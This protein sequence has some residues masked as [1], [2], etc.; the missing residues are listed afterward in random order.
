MKRPEE[1]LVRGEDETHTDWRSRERPLDEG[2]EEGR[3]ADEVSIIVSKTMAYLL[4]DILQANNKMRPSP[5]INVHNLLW[6]MQILPPQKC[7]CSNVDK[8]P[9]LHQTLSTS[10]QNITNSHHF[11]KDDVVRESD[12]TNNVPDSIFSKLGLQL[13]RRDRHPIGILKN[14]IYDYFD[15]NY[16]NSF[17]KF[18]DLCP[19][20]PV[21]AV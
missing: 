18:N 7:I 15:T 2:E 8:P 13:H 11:N 14:A 4:V 1:V 17:L 9:H 21:K 5:F 3:R 19:I 12:P 20:V 10:S 16:P 6:F